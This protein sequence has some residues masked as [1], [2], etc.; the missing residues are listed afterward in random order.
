MRGVL[1]SVKDGNPDKYSQ[2][3]QLNDAWEDGVQCGM[4]ILAQDILDMISNE[5]DEEDDQS[6]GWLE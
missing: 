6:D 5:D 1:Q 2:V 4:Y 3:G